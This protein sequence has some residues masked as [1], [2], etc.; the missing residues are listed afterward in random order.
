M[1]VL[2][3]LSVVVCALITTNLRTAWVPVVWLAGVGIWG[4]YFW[5]SNS[6]EPAPSPI[7]AVCHWPA[8]VL[9][10][11]AA[12][13]ARLY[14]IET[15]PLGPYMDELLALTRS[16]ELGHQS[17]DF[18]GHTPLVK[19]GWVETPNLYLYF[20]VLILKIFGVHYWS[21]KLFFDHSWPHRVWC[22]LSNLPN[23]P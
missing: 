7:S 20:N 6:A 8:M 18:F 12:V 17:F 14:R 19:A 3:P 13:V 15:L 9:V 11:I 1:Y 22:R 4:C 5:R 10:L 23:L 2:I 21:L 16:L